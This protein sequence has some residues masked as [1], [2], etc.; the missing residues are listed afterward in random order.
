MEVTVARE[1][2]GLV[3]RYQALL[4]V[5]EAIALNRDLP[6][7]FHDLAA[8]LHE[9]VSFDWLSLMLHDAAND[10][11]RRHVLEPPVR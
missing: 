1:Q 5:S 3:E 10:T 7:L 9:L 4:A 11:L 6:A 8:R 2:Q